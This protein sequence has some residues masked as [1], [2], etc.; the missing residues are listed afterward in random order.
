[1][2]HQSDALIEPHMPPA[3]PQEQYGQLVSYSQPAEGVDALTFLQQAQGQARFYWNDSSPIVFAG[4]GIAAELFAYGD[5]RFEAIEEKAKTLFAKATVA[6]V[7]EPLAVPRLFGGFAF[8]NDFVPDKA[9]FNFH[10][11]HF[12]LP[13]YQLLQRGE[14]AWLTIN[15][16]IPA[17]E[18]ARAILPELRE[19]LRE[20]IGE[21]KRKDVKSRKN[22]GEDKHETHNTQHAIRYPMSY[23]QW[24]TMIKAATAQIKA[25]TFQKVVL[26]R[27]CEIRFE[28]DAAVAEALAYLD[29]AYPECYRFLFEPRPHHAFYGA[30][31]E[32]LVQLNGREITT[33][34]LA[35]S[36]PRGQT[37]VEDTTL[38]RNLLAS[39]KNQHEH[40]L[41]VDAIR[42]RLTPLT[43][44]LEIP[45]EAQIYTLSNIH[46]LYTPIR[47]TLNKDIGILSLLKTMHPTPALGGT[48]RDAAM[49]FIQEAE[50]VTRGWYAAPVGWLDH[51]LDGVFGV[52][53]RSA[54]AQNNRVWAYA[55]V[56][57][58]GQSDPA[59]EWRETEVKF[60]PMLHSLRIV[61]RE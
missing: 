37:A 34:G 19:A 3:D 60:R 7:D 54:V 26:S 6:N 9:W 45:A 12:V 61:N 51:Q 24:E 35:G 8:R 39:E 42:R 43:A 17:G 28:E 47:G 57:V 1:M 30:T 23:E 50:P 29:G 59:E 36:A 33:M 58:V 31:P 22:E 38:A 21:L 46:H 52:A 27:V 13:H 41:V 53:I 44:E 48:P 32:L 55:G 49:G 16:H 15:A 18:N 2:S 20:K 10:P 5:N 40:R 14:E 11:S 25:G 56:G 4:V